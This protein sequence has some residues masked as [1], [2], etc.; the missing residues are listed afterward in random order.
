MRGGEQVFDHLTSKKMAASM[1]DLP[2]L[3]LGRQVGAGL[4][5]GMLQ[6]T[7]GVEAAARQMAAGVE[8]GVR[9]ELQIAS[10][11]KKMLA[12]M[13]DVKDGVVRGLTGSK[14]QIKAT[15]RELADS[16]WAAFSGKKTTKDTELVRLVSETNDKL[17]RL[18]TKRDSLK[19]QLAGAQELLESRVAARDQLR[20][21]ARSAAQGAS[22][23]SSLGLE[24]K[25]VTTSSIKVGLQQKLAKLRQ[26]RRYVEALAKRGLNRN[27]MRQILL[28][29]PEEGYAYASA[30]A[31]MST[32]D[33]KEVNQLQT[34]IDTEADKVGKAGSNA[35]YGAGVA[36][37]EGLVN[38]LKSQQK[39]IEQQ[40]VTIAKS[41][42]TAI[43]KALGIRS[44]SR[45]AHGIGLNFG[46]G[47][48]G[49]TRA[50]LPLVGRAVDAVAE[51]M[52]GIRP[53]PGQPVAG[54]GAG[55]AAGPS[56]SATITI[57][58]AMDPVRV[59]QEVQRVLLSLK[60]VNGINV[61]LGVA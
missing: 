11:S 6:S 12:L 37:A 16:I 9:A 26:F 23:L 42:E 35:L 61:D 10:P 47:L 32:A 15:A 5:V 48:S 39:A 40:M 60:R 41:M 58:D 4:S 36:A 29:G 14:A 45:V 21:S 50:S 22:S 25:E 57:T 52:A 2:G 17:Q 19:R 18:A 24:P 8:A 59:G 38:G 49:G 31:G 30:L 44:P 28:M 27:L 46:Q 53:M 43:K 55:V 54:I 51:R 20:A 7:A 13:K 34:Q 33:F 1:G 56:I 3:S